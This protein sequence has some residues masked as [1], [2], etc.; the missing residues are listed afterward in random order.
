MGEAATVDARWIPILCVSVL[1]H[2]VCG[3][4]VVVYAE[5]FGWESL[6]GSLSVSSMVQEEGTCRLGSLGGEVC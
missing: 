4:T 1:F 6:Y 3:G 2:G 5:A